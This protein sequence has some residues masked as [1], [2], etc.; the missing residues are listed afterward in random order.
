M[1]ET[2][3]RIKVCTDNIF[4]EVDRAYKEIIASLALIRNNERGLTDEERLNALDN[5]LSTA[6][7]CLDN[8]NISIDELDR[9]PQFWAERKEPDPGSF[10]LAYNPPFSTL[11]FET[12]SILDLIPALMPD[13]LKLERYLIPRAIY[14]WWWKV[15]VLTNPVN[16][17]GNRQQVVNQVDW[18]G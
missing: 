9:L 8:T 2:R 12:R 7:D 18:P 10:L 15:E 5:M 4:S 16:P 6:A 17:V 11:I 3:E 1:S 14:K 13:P